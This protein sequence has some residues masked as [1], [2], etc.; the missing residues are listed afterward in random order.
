MRV[1]TYT[2]LLCTLVAATAAGSW[3]AGKLLLQWLQL[4]HHPASVRLWFDYVHYMADPRYALYAQHIRWSG[5]A[6]LTPPLLLWLCAAVWLLRPRPRSLHGN[7][8]FASRRELARAGLFQRSSTGVLIGRYGRHYLRD[9]GQRF[10]LLSAPTRS[11]KGVGV[12]IPTLLDYGDSVVVLD[13]KQEN[14]DLTS[15]YRQ[16]IG[17]QVYRFSPFAGDERSHRWN[18]LHYISDHPSRRTGDIRSLAQMLYPD[19]D[20]SGNQSFFTE[21]ARNA[22]L[23]LCLYLFEIHDCHRRLQLPADPPTLGRIYRTA[24]SDKGDLKAHLQELS[25]TP[26]LSDA[27]RSAFASLLAQAPETFAGIMGTFQAPLSLWADPALDVAT[28][29]NDFLLTDVR[30]QRMSLYLCVPPNRLQQAAMVFNLFFAQLIHEN[31]RTL[32]QQDAS[33]RMQCLLLMDEFT[34]IGPVSIIA[35][36]VSYM[37]GYN[38]RLLPIIQSLSQ[39][40]ATYGAESARTL[41]ANHATH[42]LFTPRE[43]RDANDYSET[44]GYTTV[45]RRQRTTGRDTTYSEVEERRALLLP[46]ELKALDAERE[47]LLVSGMPHPAL[48]HKIRYYRDRKFRQRLLPPVA[49]PPLFSDS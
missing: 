38:L 7:A 37:A 15:G 42:I 22:F 46:Q 47:I 5:V 33:L 3:T 24:V 18:P 29:G 10:I 34:S 20:G 45:R 44:L 43:Q 4:E 2:S 9:N 31:T 40:D 35:H 25:A 14:F 28:S 12:V 41:L 1:L 48:V 36:A 6:G 21:H 19:G 49:V 26:Y 16:H 39:L 13:I 11:G 30:R 23:A 8:R 32:P 27:C 17:Q